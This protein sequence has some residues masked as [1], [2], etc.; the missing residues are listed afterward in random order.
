[1]KVFSSAVLA[2]L[3][4]APLAAQSASA[5]EPAKGLEN[6]DCAIWAATEIGTGVGADRQMQLSIALAWFVGRYEGK[7]GRNIDDV[8]VARQPQLSEA[9]IKALASPCEARFKSF[10]QRLIS[11]SSRIRN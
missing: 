2:A 9:D 8:L 3:L 10:G 7:S 6:V 1:M 5:E 4:A 11:M